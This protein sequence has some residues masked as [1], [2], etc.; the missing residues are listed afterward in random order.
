LLVTFVC[1]H[2][3]KLDAYLQ[4]YSSGYNCRIGQ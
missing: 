1:E 2:Y 4:G 3:M